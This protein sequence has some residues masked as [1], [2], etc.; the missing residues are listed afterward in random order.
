MFFGALNIHKCPKNIS[1]RFTKSASPQAGLLTNEL[2]ELRAR[3]VMCNQR[4][5]QLAGDVW[6]SEAASKRK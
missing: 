6:L 2:R 3:K 5:Y 1:R 4:C